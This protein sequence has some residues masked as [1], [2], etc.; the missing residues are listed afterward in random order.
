MMTIVSGDGNRCRLIILDMAAG[1]NPQ[2]KAKDRCEIP[3]F[4]R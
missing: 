1:D 4:S 2:L 3:F